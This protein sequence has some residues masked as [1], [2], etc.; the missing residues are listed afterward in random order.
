M[1]EGSGPV[2][3]IVMVLHFFRALGP[4]SNY[5]HTLDFSL[6]TGRGLST[7][8]TPHVRQPLIK[9]Q[10]FDFGPYQILD[11][12]GGPGYI[13]PCKKIGALTTAIL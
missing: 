7:K 8:I 10:Y 6:G 5:P 2:L 3:K 13:I 1:V 11:Q 9:L 12:A 4:Y